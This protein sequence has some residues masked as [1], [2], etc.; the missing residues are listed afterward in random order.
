MKV[1]A[2]NGDIYCA[3]ASRMFG[4][5]VVKHGVNGELR[6]KGKIAELA[7]GYGGGTG[8]LT[9]MGALEMGLKEEELQ[10]LVTAWRNSNPN[11]VKFWWAVDN[12]VMTAITEL[13]T[14]ETHGLKFAC[15][16]GMLFLSPSPQPE[17]SPA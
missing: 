7:L 8:A 5:P 17:S 16:S 11:I 3:A 9:A 14:T 10:P 2:E 12:A 13:T 6:Q 4:V 1:F 15:K